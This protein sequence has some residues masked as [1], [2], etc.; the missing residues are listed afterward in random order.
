MKFIR[1]IALVFASTFASSAYAIGA[2]G[3]LVV[4]TL[5]DDV[6]SAG[7]DLIKQG[8]A[9]ANDVLIT[10]GN[11]A[12]LA[13]NA[14]AIAYEGQLTKTFDEVEQFD[15]RLSDELR[16]L[17]ESVDKPLGKAEEIVA[18]SGAV[19]A[20][21]PGASKAPTILI[22][23]GE[24]FQLSPHV[25]ARTTTSGTNL[26]SDVL[27]LSS[28]KFTHN[29]VGNTGTSMS[30]ESTLNEG[31]QIG[32]PYVFFETVPVVARFQDDGFFGGKEISY[33]IPLTVMDFSAVQVRLVTL[34]GGK[35]R[36]YDAP[37]TVNK[38][39][40]RNSSHNYRADYVA[41]PGKRIDVSSF[42]VTKWYRHSECGQGTKY[43]I[44]QKDELAIRV[45]AYGKEE[46][47]LGKSCGTEI[48]YTVRTYKD[49]DTT[50]EVLTDWQ[51]VSLNSPLAYGANAE[52]VRLELKMPADNKFVFSE[53]SSQV[54]FLEVI[55]AEE[56]HTVVLRPLP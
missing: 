44:E 38:S 7:E 29:I 2:I 4:G 39:H 47:G 25:P 15:E 23:K 18:V 33:T 40:G 42:K 17:V 13:A 24:V 19:V 41:P 27:E 43:D 1:I 3:G 28:S 9:A 53:D 55:D 56:T 11:Q 48:N 30:F 52:F 14:L 45:R 21:L 5:I 26:K 16:R 12:I 32:N 31:A 34:V 35:T 36:V 8:Q 20:L 54:P 50:T 46:G 49:V 51:P 10:A 6:K 22:F 37:V